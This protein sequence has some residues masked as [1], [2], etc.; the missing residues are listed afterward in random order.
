MKCYNHPDRDGIAICRSCGKAICRECA[1]ESRDGIACQQSCLASLAEKSA[2]NAQQAVHLKN[3]KRTNLLGSLF[4]IAMGILFIFFS[5]QGFGLV[6]DFIFLLGIGF[7]LYGI[8]AQ[9]VNMV[10][11]LKSSKNKVNK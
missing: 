3:L 2:L 8:V 5:F 1:M 11:F 7:T 6:Y 10:I 4:S 9:A